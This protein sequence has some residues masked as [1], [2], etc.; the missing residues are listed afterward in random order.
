[1][2][3]LFFFF[4]FF[5]SFSLYIL[6]LSFADFVS[7]CAVL[8]FSSVS[9]DFFLI[10]LFD[11]LVCVFVCLFACVLACLCCFSLPLSKH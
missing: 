7:M 10:S 8:C 3:V 9:F 4:F 1:M 5:F 2:D 11:L 6:F